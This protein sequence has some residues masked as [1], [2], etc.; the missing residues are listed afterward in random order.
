MIIKRSIEKDGNIKPEAYSLLNNLPN[1]VLLHKLYGDL[2]PLGLY[3]RSLSRVSNSFLEVLN[4]LRQIETEISNSKTYPDDFSDYEPSGLLKSQ[5]ELLHSIQSHFDDCFR[6][7][8]VTSPYPNMDHITSRK[9]KSMERSLSAWLFITEHPTFPFFK[10]DIQKYKTFVDLI[11][12]KLKHEHGRL[13]DMI[14]FN[15]LEIHEKRLGYYIETSGVNSEGKVFLGPDPKIHLNREGFSYARDLSIHF[16]N[17]YKISYHL[18]NALLKSF[19]EQHNINLTGKF[20][21]E[22]ISTD[23]V[24]IKDKICDLKLKFFPSEYPKPLPMIE[25]DS[26]RKDTLILALDHEFRLNSD[27]FGKIR[28]I[29]SWTAD[30]TTK[31]FI[32]PK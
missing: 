17:I 24:D 26:H 4:E 18:K 5:K 8:K 28:T 13:R 30:G 29:S 31:S 20:Y 1:E 6:I 7:L 3:N 14:M 19:E 2:H 22:D 15:D 16:Y 11:V 21:F 9:R 23:F 32:I 12:N 25:W 10:K 27:F